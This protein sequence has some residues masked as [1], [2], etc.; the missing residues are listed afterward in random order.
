M[1]FRLIRD[2]AEKSCLQRSKDLKENLSSDSGSDDNPSDGAL[3]EKVITLVL[4]VNANG[5]GIFMI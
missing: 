5:K 4:P 2:E 1:Q 3:N